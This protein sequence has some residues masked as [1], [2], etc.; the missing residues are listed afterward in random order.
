MINPCQHYL[1]N[2]L[3]LYIISIF[4]G[5]LFSFLRLLLRTSFSNPSKK[6]IRNPKYLSQ[7]VESNI[8]NKYTHMN[9]F[10]LI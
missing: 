6:I 7:H 4:F 10:S 3:I 8:L 1:P 2:F 9:K 5:I